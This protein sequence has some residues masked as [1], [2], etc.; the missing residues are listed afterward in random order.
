MT[1]E[2]RQTDPFAQKPIKTKVK[3]Y[4]LQGPKVWSGRS[5]G[6][7]RGL[8]APKMVRRN[9]D[10]VP[11]GGTENRYFST[12]LLFERPLLVLVPFL[13]HFGCLWASF[14]D[15][16]NNFRQLWAHF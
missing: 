14:C 15:H 6:R 3:A 9:V 11:P 7:S 1:F 2:S 12:G 13:V 4:I 10:A 16:F 8:L 5:D